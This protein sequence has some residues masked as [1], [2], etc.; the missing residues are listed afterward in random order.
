M[1]TVSPVLDPAAADLA[2]PD[3]PVLDTHALDDHRSEA[4][5]TDSTRLRFREPVSGR[6]VVDAAWW[7]RSA[8]L[9]AELPDLLEA[10]WARGT[11]I[12][13]V[14]YRLGA[15]D[16][17]PHR[18]LLGGRIVRLG[19]FRSLDPALLSLRDSRGEQRI[20]VLVIP[21]ET[22]GSQAEA[23]LRIASAADSLGG[24]QDI[25]AQA[26]VQTSPRE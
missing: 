7:P 11:D 4:R 1:T 9:A 15:W 6:G 24:P 23:A 13:R 19:G 14:S 8:D 10:V 22:P 12:R 2:A 5:P 3:V 17:P 16:A 25:L 21:A 26:G 20:D 18:L